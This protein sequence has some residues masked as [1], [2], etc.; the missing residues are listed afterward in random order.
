MPVAQASPPVTKYNKK[1]HTHT[2]TQEKLSTR[3]KHLLEHPAIQKGGIRNW[4]IAR[5]EIYINIYIS[6]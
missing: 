6:I 3:G 1:N 2:H 4:E 5:K